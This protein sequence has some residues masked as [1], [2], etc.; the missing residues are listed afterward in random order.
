MA[1]AV[2]AIAALAACSG[3][4]ANPSGVASL[5]S[6]SPDPETSATPQ[7]SMDPEEAALAFAECMRE[8]GVDMP[9]PQ[10]G[11][12]GDF[13]VTVNG[14]PGSLDMA[15]MQAAQEACQ[16]LMPGPMGEPRE[17]TAEEKDAMLGFAQ[18]M[19]NNGIDMPDPVFEGGGMVRIGG[20]ATAAGGN[21]EGPAF[22]P[23]S[24]EFQAASEACRA[25]FGELMPGGGPGADGG[26]SVEVAP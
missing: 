22:D 11:S 7:A 10:V 25:E 16:H 23:R 15:E 18:C 21:G 26:P 24:E 1:L 6:Q 9:D 13:R 4:A 3:A 20:P 17:L 2:L 5:G 12:N 14:G 8:H 19:R